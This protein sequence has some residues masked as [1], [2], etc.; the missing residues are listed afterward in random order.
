MAFF[1]KRFH[2][3]GTPPGTLTEVPATESAPLRIHL[4]DYNAAEITV[5]DD[6]DA[7]ECRPFLQL[8]SVTWVHVQGQPTEVAL[9]EIGE[10]FRLH[11]LALEDV[12]NR[13]QRPKVETFNDHL[14][15]IMALPLI[16][17]PLWC[18]H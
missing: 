2:P 8:D 5:Y 1:T 9:R 13:G 16:C 6:I 12:S 3:P 14:F 18:C 10:I 15:A 17:L 11:S 7:S 4:I